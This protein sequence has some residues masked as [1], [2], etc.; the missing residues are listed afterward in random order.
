MIGNNISLV[1]RRAWPQGEAMTLAIPIA[2]WAGA[3]L[4]LAAYLLLSLRRIA[5]TGPAFQ[6][7]NVV[8]GGGVA[9]HSASNGAWASA[10][11]NLIWIAIGVVALVRRPRTAD[12]EPG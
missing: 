7:A 12:R 1:S 5:A 2:G 6:L 3:A 11:L 8:G 4:L 10:A 9:L